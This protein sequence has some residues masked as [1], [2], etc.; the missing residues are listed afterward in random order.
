MK[1]LIFSD[2]HGNQ[3]AFD[4]F[5][6]SKLVKKIDKLVFLGDLVGYGPN[7]N[8]V[9][10]RFS[11]L[12]NIGKLGHKQTRFFFTFDQLLLQIDDDEGVFQ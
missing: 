6:D 5:L 11:Q 10:Q 2:I 7:P 9:V 4:T 8:E 12:K 3:E 1:Y